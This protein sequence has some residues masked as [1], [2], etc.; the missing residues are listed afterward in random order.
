VLWGPEYRLIKKEKP[1]FSRK[2][3]SGVVRYYL[4]DNFYE[5]WFRFMSRFQALREINQKER[6]FEKIWEMLPEYEGFKLEALIKRIFIELNPFDLE[7]NQVGR[8]WD[9]KGENEIDLILLDD[10][11]GRAYVVEVKRSLAKSLKKDE[12]IK[13]Y[14]KVASVIPLANYDVH[15]LYA[16]IDGQDIVIV[17]ENNKRFVL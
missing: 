9:R 6:A 14:T 12:K 15:Y 5:F 2:A 10:D 11:S 1:I 4:A 17:D 3:K 13:L 7:F 16:G 8:H